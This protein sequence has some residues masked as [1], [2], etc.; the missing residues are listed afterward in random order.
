MIHLL[1]YSF[2]QEDSLFMPSSIVIKRNGLPAQITS[3]LARV[4][5]VLNTY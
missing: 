4:N 3:D 2:Q 1:M 5:A